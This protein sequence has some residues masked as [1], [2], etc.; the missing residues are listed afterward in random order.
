MSRELQVTVDMSP[1]MPLQA[2]RPG[3]QARLVRPQLGYGR[4]KLIGPTTHGYIYVAA[5]IGPGPFP[6]VL[7]SRRRSA[8]IRELKPTAQGLAAMADVVRVKTFRAIV[9]P[10]PALGRQ[11]LKA[12]RSVHAA[13]Y[14]VTTPV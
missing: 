7:P 3:E 4:V 8:L 1:A 11:Y 6:F 9:L 5:A 2:H 13:H 12:L 14:Y 10:P